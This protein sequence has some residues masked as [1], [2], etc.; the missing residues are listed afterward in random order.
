MGN[1]KTLFCEFCGLPITNEEI[2]RNKKHHSACA[3]KKKLE[4]SKS[5]YSVMKSVQAEL[6]KN[7][8]ILAALYG[9]FGT[10]AYIPL[11]VLLKSNFNF[12]VKLFDH[13]ENGLYGIGVGDY[14]YY[15]F[16]NETFKLFKKVNI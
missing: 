4:R 13:Q 5:T 6:K 10:E 1:D 8:L 3:Y 12:G 2:T 16:E 11:G 15:Y 9:Q 14:G 7:D